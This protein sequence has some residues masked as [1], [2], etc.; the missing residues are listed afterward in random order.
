M[1][2]KTTATFLANSPP[3]VVSEI[4]WLN[5]YYD[6]IINAKIEPLFSN[7][8]EYQS[9]DLTMLS[10]VISSWSRIVRVISL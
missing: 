5:H 8:S 7:Y 4:K 10:A 9:E 3:E 6:N 1:I 2:E